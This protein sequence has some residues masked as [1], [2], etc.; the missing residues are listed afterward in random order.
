MLASDGDL[1][2]ELCTRGGCPSR[3]AK[4]YRA[5]VPLLLA[6][7]STLSLAAK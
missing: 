7:R 2:R 3:T 5:S 6:S 4:D 1:R